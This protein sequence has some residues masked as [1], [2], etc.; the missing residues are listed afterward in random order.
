M[1]PIVSRRGEHFGERKQYSNTHQ[2][3]GNYAPATFRVSFASASNWIERL[4]QEMDVVG[5]CEMNVDALVR[6]E[7]VESAATRRQGADW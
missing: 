2:K 7:M 4:L 5:A 3:R 6:S 1:I